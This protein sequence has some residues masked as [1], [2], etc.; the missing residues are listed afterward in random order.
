MSGSTATRERVALVTGAAAGLGRA[1]ALALK[2]EGLSVFGTTRRPP[3]R[4]VATEFPLLSL[5][6]RSDAQGDGPGLRWRSAARARGHR[7]RRSDRCRRR[8]RGRLRDPDRQG[9]SARAPVSCRAGRRLAS[10]AQAAALVLVR[11]R[12]PMEVRARRH[13]QSLNLPP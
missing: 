7:T 13:V 8:P 3:D 2:K 5:D 1:I 4:T 12:H 11:A 10:P 6:V 9:P